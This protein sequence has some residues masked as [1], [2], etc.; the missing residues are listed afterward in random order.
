M[1]EKLTGYITKRKWYTFMRENRSM[2]CLYAMS[3]C[4]I[5]CQSPKKGKDENLSSSDRKIPFHWNM[6]LESSLGKSKVNE[7]LWEHKSIYLQF[8]MTNDKLMRF[9]R[10]IL[11]HS[12]LQKP[13]KFHF[14]RLFHLTSYQFSKNTKPKPIIP[15]L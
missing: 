12:F 14:N 9:S 15:P 11:T 7:L 6:K 2:R 5:H 3:K 4:F 8:Q 1:N 10:L 13:Y